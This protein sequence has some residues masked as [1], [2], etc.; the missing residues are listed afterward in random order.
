MTKPNLMLIE[1]GY[2][3][4][5]TVDREN[6]FSGAEIETCRLHEYHYVRIDDGKQFPQLCVGGET[7]GNTLIYRSDEGLASACHAKLYKTR[8]GYEKAK[9]KLQTWEQWANEGGKYQ[10]AIKAQKAAS[11]DDPEAYYK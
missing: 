3:R 1:N 6:G 5:V 4:L 11:L 10:E 7:T 8:E 2:A 9:A